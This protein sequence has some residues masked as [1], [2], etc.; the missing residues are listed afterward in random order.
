[1][2]SRVMETGSKISWRIISI[3]SESEIQT[4]NEKKR[5]RGTG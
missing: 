3:T 2:R 4:Y 1:M 5:L